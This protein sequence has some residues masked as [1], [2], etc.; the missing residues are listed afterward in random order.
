MRSAV[1]VSSLRK[2]GR[3]GSFNLFWAAFPLLLGACKIS[4]ITD[5]EVSLRYEL[6]ISSV[7]ARK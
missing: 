1:F 4:A 7:L 2:S 6:L 5:L 3:N